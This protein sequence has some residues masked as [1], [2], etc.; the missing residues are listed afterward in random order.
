MKTI[1][2]IGGGLSGI[3]SAM[4]LLYIRKDILVKIINASHPIALGVA[5]STN[6]PDHLLK[7]FLLLVVNLNYIL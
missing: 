5:Y 6:D 2:I 3:L 1:I 7:D 4:Q